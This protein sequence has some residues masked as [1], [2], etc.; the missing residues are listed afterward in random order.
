MQTLQQASNALSQSLLYPKFCSPVK[1]TSA[2]KSV[3]IRGRFGSLTL[4]C[5]A[6]LQSESSRS[7]EGT[8]DSS[9]RPRAVNGER[10][11]GT[12]AMAGG[13]PKGLGCSLEEG[14]K[15][16]NH[17]VTD[18]NSTVE[19]TGDVIAKLKNGFKTFKEGVFKCV[20]SLIH[21]ILTTLYIPDLCCS[22]F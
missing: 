17:V 2:V 15:L 18:E 11:S 9:L 14:Y 4:R 7:S 13:K 8:S 12:V 3:H 6:P 21:I 19:A 10:N 22:C 5:R 1:E 16:T 20:L